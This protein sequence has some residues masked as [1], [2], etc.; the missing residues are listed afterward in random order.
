[1][2]T[3]ISKTYITIVGKIY[4][5]KLKKKQTYNNTITQVKLNFLAMKK[6]FYCMR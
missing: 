5:N 2:I 6:T 4:F 3:T 1:M